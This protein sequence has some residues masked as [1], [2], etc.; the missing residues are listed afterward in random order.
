MCTV[1]RIIYMYL[2]LQQVEEEAKKGKADSSE[3]AL[4]G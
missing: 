4:E 3:K 2:I 1:T